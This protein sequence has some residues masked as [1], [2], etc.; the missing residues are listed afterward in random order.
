MTCIML[1]C[2]QKV[3]FDLETEEVMERLV[4]HEDDGRMPLY[5]G[6]LIKTFQRNWGEGYMWEDPEE[7]EFGKLEKVEEWKRFQESEK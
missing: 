7:S 5:R 4:A 6:T 2:R 3:K 1:I